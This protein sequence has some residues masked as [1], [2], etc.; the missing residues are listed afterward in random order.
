MNFCMF[1]KC[2]SVIIQQK[3]PEQTLKAETPDTGD[4]AEVWRP[5]DQ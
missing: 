3:E 4:V 1:Q 5:S 2:A